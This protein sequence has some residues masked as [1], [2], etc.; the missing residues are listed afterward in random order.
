MHADLA[1]LFTYDIL[2]TARPCQSNT[3]LMLMFSPQVTV[4][5]KQSEF[6][7]GFKALQAAALPT[8]NLNKFVHPALHDNS[9]PI[10]M[11][12]T[13]SDRFE[14]CYLKQVSYIRFHGCL[15]CSVSNVL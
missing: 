12:V 6:M 9:K 15:L 11:I 4:A 1:R 10:H 7:G 8:C 3:V 5:K 13:T 14:T 2:R